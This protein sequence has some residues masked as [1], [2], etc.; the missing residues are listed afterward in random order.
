MAKT[1]AIDTRK[2]LELFHFKDHLPLAKDALQK[3]VSVPSVNEKLKRL[4]AGANW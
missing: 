1:D 2:I 3:V 4:T